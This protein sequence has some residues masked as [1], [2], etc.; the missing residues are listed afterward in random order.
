MTIAIF[1]GPSWPGEGARDVIPQAVICGPAACGDIYR[2]ARQKP[3]AIGLV[4]GFFEHR[5]SVWHKEIAW[6]LKAGIWVYGAASMGALRAVELAPEGM[7]GVGWVFEQFRD[8]CLEDDDEVAVVHASHE[9]GYKPQSDALVNLRRTLARAVADGVLPAQAVGAIVQDLKST[10]YALRSAKQLEQLVLKHVGRHDSEAFARWLA[11]VGAVEQKRADALEMVRVMREHLD[12][13]HLSTP[14]TPQGWSFEHTNA[15]QALIERTSTGD[16]AHSS[17]LQP[18]ALNVRL[19]ES[20]LADRGG[21]AIALRAVVDWIKANDPQR[22]QALLT[23]ALTRVGALALARERCSRV[24]EAAVQSASE[25]FRA[26]RGL[27]TPEQTAHWLACV[28]LDLIDFSRMMA[29]DVLCARLAPELRH[30]MVQAL[31][32][33]AVIE[34]GRLPSGHAPR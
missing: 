7:I 24:D 19:P 4:D 5:L 6:A 11:R 2:I 22:C 30:I 18:P 32:D 26:D 12:A 20:E 9:H 31:R 3:V 29:D 15:W 13:G 16:A 34:H 17:V 23:H 8:G 1:C 14:F 27:F 28:G 25:S 21:E 33:V 10:F